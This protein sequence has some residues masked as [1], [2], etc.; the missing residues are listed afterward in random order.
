MNRID[1]V[2]EESCSRFIGMPVCAVLHDGTRHYGVIS[3]VSGGKLI[4]NDTPETSQTSGSV[5]RSKGK[6]STSAR[7]KS[8]KA[9]KGAPAGQAAISAFPAEVGYGYPYPSPYPYP[10][11]FGGRIALDLAAIALLFLLFI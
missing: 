6:A 2:T 1:P 10:Y 8:G 7:P 9:K 5:K 3:R 11:P 4:L